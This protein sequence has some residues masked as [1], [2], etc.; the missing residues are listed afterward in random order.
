MIDEKSFEEDMISALENIVAIVRE[1][2][3]RKAFMEK[4]PEVSLNDEGTFGAEWETIYLIWAGK[5]H[6]TPQR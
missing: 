2:T 5:P 3:L 1:D 6:R 4:Y